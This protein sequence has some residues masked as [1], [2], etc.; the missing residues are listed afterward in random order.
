MAPK[1]DDPPSYG[2]ITAPPPARAHSPMRLFPTGE[3]PQ[4]LEAQYGV[5]PNGTLQ[6]M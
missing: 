5:P 1:V 6:S 4:D 2:V 3:P